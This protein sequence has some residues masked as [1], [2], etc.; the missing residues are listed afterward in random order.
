MLIDC[1]F[2]GN[3][4]GYGGGIS[5]E[6]GSVFTPSQSSNPT[7]VDCIFNDNYAFFSGGGIYN[8]DSNPNLTNCTISKN[9]ADNGAAVF[10]GSPKLT[11]CIVWYNV[12]PQIISDAS[13]SFSNIQGSWDGEGNIDEYPLFAD[14]NN[15]D[16]HLKSQAG[17]WDP[18]SGGWV[19]D[20]VTSPC[21]DAGDPNSSIGD[22]PSPNGGIIN[23]GAYGGSSQASKSVD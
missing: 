12:S 23:M 8:S 7:I 16:Y 20:D 4:A 9:F 21:I 15:G 5:N 19:I 14:P 2:T 1:R 11:N 3:Y 17:R 13:V 18:A 10:G 6:W 22:E